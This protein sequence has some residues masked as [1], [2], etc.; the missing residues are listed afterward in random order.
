MNVVHI[1]GHVYNDVF[2]DN[3]MFQFPE[4]ESFVY[5]GVCKWGITTVS[6]DPM[7][8][9]YMFT[10]TSDMDEAL[11]RRWWVDPSIAYVYRRNVDVETNPI[12]YVNWRNMQLVK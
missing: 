12:Y 9:L 4:D 10:S 2:P 11:G 3:I 8:S 7:K 5:I 6:I 1:S